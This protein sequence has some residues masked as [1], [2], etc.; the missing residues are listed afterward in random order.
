MTFHWRGEGKAVFLCFLLN[1][2][3][4]TL[5]YD[6]LYF[7]STILDVRTLAAQLCVWTEPGISCFGSNMLSAN[8]RGV[9]TPSRVSLSGLVPTKVKWLD[10]A[11]QLPLGI[12][13]YEAHKDH[14]IRNRT[15]KTII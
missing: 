4:L 15:R 13:T 9:C 14:Y 1:V 8:P 11:R 2:Y 10:H 6:S 7:L 5:S 12:G 3:F